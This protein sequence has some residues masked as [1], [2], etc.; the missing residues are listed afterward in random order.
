MVCVGPLRKEFVDLI[1]DLAQ[2]WKL[3]LVPSA[4]NR[5]TTLQQLKNAKEFVGDSAV[6]AGGVLI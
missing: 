1:A 3:G 6:T 4:D 5:N 2:N